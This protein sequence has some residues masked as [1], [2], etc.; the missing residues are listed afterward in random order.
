M[1]NYAF[2]M[3]FVFG[4]AKYNYVCCVCYT[5]CTTGNCEEGKTGKNIKSDQLKNNKLYKM[6]REPKR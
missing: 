2:S 3:Y 5:N 4:S 1:S 6:H